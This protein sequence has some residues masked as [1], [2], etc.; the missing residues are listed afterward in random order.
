MTAYSFSGSELAGTAPPT[1]GVAAEEH[2]PAT[3]GILYGLD[4]SWSSGRVW[5]N[6]PSSPRRLI[7]VAEGLTSPGPITPV[8]RIVINGLTVWEGTTPFPRDGWATMAWVIDKPQIL[9]A[10]YLQIALTLGV[11]GSETSEPWVAIATFTVYAE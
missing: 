10:P 1:T 9:A 4:S 5:I 7:I 2:L 11:P 6:T 3:V 8:L